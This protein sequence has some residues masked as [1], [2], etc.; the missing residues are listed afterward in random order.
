MHGCERRHEFAVRRQAAGRVL[1]ACRP[2]T[3]STALPYDEAARGVRSTQ[4]S[5]VGNVSLG[6]RTLKLGGAETA[7]PLGVP[8]TRH[9]DS[10]DSR[11]SLPVIELR[12]IFVAG[13]E[14]RSM[15]FPLILN[16]AYE[17][18]PSATNSASVDITFA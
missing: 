11:T 6:H 7:E 8:R 18:P 9:P 14:R 12:L 4:T 5:A 2:E 16:A 1:P 10:R 17:E 13:I 3:L 15:L